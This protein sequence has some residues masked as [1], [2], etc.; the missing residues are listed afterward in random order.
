MLFC[1]VSRRGT[2]VPGPYP[3][4]HTQTQQPGPPRRLPT[5]TLRLTGP[6]HVCGPYMR[7]ESRVGG[8]LPVTTRHTHPE[9]LSRAPSLGERQ[10]DPCQPPLRMGTPTQSRSQQV[11][12]GG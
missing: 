8:A 2:P 11:Y 3:M 9:P 12:T 4:L 5:L 7:L 10:A 1:H 6:R